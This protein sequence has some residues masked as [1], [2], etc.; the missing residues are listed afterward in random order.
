[1]SMTIG[2]WTSYYAIE[3]AKWLNTVVYLVGL[4][5]AVW[6][7]FRCRK[8]A[9]LVVALYFAFVLFAWHV[10]PPI[11]HAIYVR[12]TPAETQQK[13]NADF[14]QAVNQLLAQEGHPVPTER[15][16]IQIAPIVLVIGLWLLARR[17]PEYHRPNPALE[18][19]PTAP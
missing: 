18:P 15:I 3:A 19:T 12:R 9:Y 5:I 2:D 7:F 17:E 13:M 14:Q 11:S 10:W 1:M 8:R 6:A 16:N 4:G